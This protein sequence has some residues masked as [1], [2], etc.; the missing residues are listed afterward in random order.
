MKNKFFTITPLKWEYD[1]KRK[2]H[3]AHTPF[4]T[5]YVYEIDKQFQWAWN[6]IDVGEEFNCASI[7]SGKELAEKDW[8]VTIEECL[9]VIEAK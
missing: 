8:I 7:K 3:V 2:L 5:Y 1:R 4:L 6:M 9:T